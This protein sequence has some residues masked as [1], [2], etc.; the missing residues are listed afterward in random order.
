[1]M[2]YIYRSTDQIRRTIL[3]GIGWHYGGMRRH[4]TALWRHWTSIVWTNRG[5]LPVS[6]VMNILD[7]QEDEVDVIIVVR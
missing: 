4:M 7:V 2:D 6:H 5:C 3:G 1:M